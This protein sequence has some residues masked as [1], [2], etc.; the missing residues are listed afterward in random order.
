[1]LNQ[2]GQL[3]SLYQA[4]AEPARRIMVERLTRGPAS[5]SELAKPLDMSLSAVMQHL[6]VLEASG[7][8]RTE[9]TGRVRT[10]RIEPSALR[11]AEEW[12]SAQRGMWEKRLDRLGDYL[13]KTG[14]DTG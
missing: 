9:K 11:M 6:Q 4:L 3:D 7:L 14:D 8:V 13:A 5:V 2:S 12:L 10:C 1:M